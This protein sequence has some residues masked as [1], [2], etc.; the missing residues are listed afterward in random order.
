MFVIHQLMIAHNLAAVW[1]GNC[2]FLPPPSPQMTGINI[3]DRTDDAV[4]K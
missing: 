4:T 3:A 1:G 2:E